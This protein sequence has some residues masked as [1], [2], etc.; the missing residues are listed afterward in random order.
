MM[1][2]PVPKDQPYIAATWARSMLSMHALQRHG[3]MRTGRQIGPILDA[4]LDRPDTRALLCVKD[5]DH[6]VI[7]GYVVYVEG[8]SVPVVHWLYTRDHDDEGNPLRGQGVAAALLSRIGVDRSRAVICTST[9]PA[10]ESMRGR[11]RASIHVPLTDF[12][13]PG[14]SKP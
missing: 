12:L 4:V 9:G 5:S 13:A 14:P 10:S 1:R 2:G 6:D 11:Y 3:T 7:T 8:P